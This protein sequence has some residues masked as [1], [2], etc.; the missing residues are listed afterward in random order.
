MPGCLHET[1]QIKS[2]CGVITLKA[3][4]SIADG[5]SK[6][7]GEICSLCPI[8]KVSLCPI[9]KISEYATNNDSTELSNEAF[10]EFLKGIKTVRPSYHWKTSTLLIQQQEESHVNSN[11]IGRIKLGALAEISLMRKFRP[12]NFGLMPHQNAALPKP[13]KGAMR[14]IEKV[15]GV[16]GFV[17]TRHRRKIYSAR[18]SCR[19]SRG[20]K[21]PRPWV[22]NLNMRGCPWG[23]AEPRPKSPPLRTI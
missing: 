14:R 23:M 7:C 15:P 19:S 6:Y 3:I 10:I 4:S 20:R 12:I 17:R 16:R 1:S 9:K 11:R 21:K 8:N 5:L 13:E 18:K 22:L 2:N